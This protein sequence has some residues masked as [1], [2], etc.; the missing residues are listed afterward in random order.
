MAT[1]VR[2]NI[3]EIPAFVATRQ[4]L[5]AI[6]EFCEETRA[7]RYSFDLDV[8][9]S[10]SLYD[11]MSEAGLTNTELVDVVTVK[12]TDG[13]TPVIPK[14]FKWLDDNLS[15]WRSTTA[16]NAHWYVL[17]S[18][19]V[20][21]LVYT[22]ASTT[23]AKYHVRMALKPLL[24]SQ[25]VSDVLENKYDEAFIHGALARLYFLPR[26]PWTDVNLG[27]YH[28]LKFENYWASAKAEA[29]DEFQTGVARKVRY[30]GL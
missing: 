6:R 23:S 1:D 4:L 11:L 14:T 27:Q 17:D 5:R 15:D 16:E 24:S 26:K 20:I 2:A 9:A 18:N 30:G 10:E 21:R 8:T 7:W 28:R 12:N 29:A 13:S 22:P 19:N 3:P 25:A